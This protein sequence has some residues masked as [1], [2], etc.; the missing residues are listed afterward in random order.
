M[1]RAV[2]FDGWLKDQYCFH[3]DMPMRSTVALEDL[4][5]FHATMLVW[6][7]LGGGSIS[8]PFLHHEAY[9]P[10][11]PRLRMYGYMNDAEFI[12]R[13]N[14]RGMKLF[15]IVFEVQ[16]WEFPAE[17]GPDGELL[18][19]N[20][21]GG[22]ENG[23]YGLREFSKGE[24]EQ[25][26]EKKWK[27]FYPDGIRNSDG[28]EVTDL[29]EECAARDYN[30][31]LIHARWVEQE[32]DGQ[33][34]LQMCR[35]NP[36]WRDYL[37]KII[38]L[39]IDAGVAGVQLDESELPITALRHGGC[40]CKDCRRGF[41][42][43]L[44]GL[45]AEGRLDERYREIGLDG[46]DYAAY[47]REN[48]ID[49]P[50][51]ED[52]PLFREYWEFQLTMITK[53]FTELTDYIR[54]YSKRTRGEEVL[55]S[56]NFFN[57]SPVYYTIR[58]TVD[59]V[60]TEME[61]TLFRQPYWYRYISGFAAGRD[62]VVA[63]NPYGG[64]VP[65]LVKELNRGRGYDLYRLFLLEAAACG[66]NMSIP[67]GG[68]MGNTMK[69]AFHPPKEVT[70]EVADYLKEHDACISR[71]SGAT[72]AVL[73]S[74]PSCYWTESTKKSTGNLK[75][76]ENS[77]LFFTPTNLDDPD[78]TRLPFWEI[79]RWMSSRQEIYDV[80]TLGGGMVEDTCSYE[81]L[82]G[83]ELL[84]LPECTVL[85][86]RQKDML[87]RYVESGR[88]LLVFGQITVD[89]PACA[90][91]LKG[92]EHVIFCDNPEAK[93]KAVE[94]FAAAYEQAVAGVREVRINQ[95]DPGIQLHKT[96]SGQA[97]HLLN[98]RYDAQ[99]D[100]CIPAEG[101][102]L[103]VPVKERP[104]AVMWHGL[105]EASVVPAWEYADSA[106]RVT[107]PALRIYGILEITEA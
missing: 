58:D 41:T 9:G 56:G 20:L 92:Q 73:Y 60:T 64:I 59:V 24:H 8:L 84:V 27:D 35:N 63:E 6:A 72:V 75:E 23:W 96:K 66:C 90:D 97:V 68:W 53:Y 55:V 81:E 30:G 44:K 32:A 91:W 52:V 11:D 105:G 61:A 87:R 47:I 89:D 14:E 93:D 46:F 49:F 45:R 2:Y 83:Y 85:T 10:V 40:F 102:V 13:C 26:F 57:G 99:A 15:G 98:Y 65:E 100:A 67:Y 78:T 70:C 76:D 22:R 25:L 18:G 77:I 5:R 37:K 62:V 88:K 16:G 38:E 7:G 107:L 3:P 74:W 106:I 28:E 54:S 48:G 39:Q 71:V 21:T 42:E 95:P 43:Y 17:Y 101:I 19:L 104:K 69:D 29:L 34:C 50:D 86:Q 1:E 103:T 33:Y 79:I 94:A 82:D 36:V 31:N 4:E 12:R 51:G 80:V